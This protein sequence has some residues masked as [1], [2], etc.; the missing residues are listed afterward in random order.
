MSRTHS[1]QWQWRR[2]FTYY[3]ILRYSCEGEGEQ[4]GE[5]IHA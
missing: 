1:Y 5:I 4:I 3:A 2:A